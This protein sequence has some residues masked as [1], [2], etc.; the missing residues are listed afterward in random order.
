[1][2]ADRK[3][4]A[5]L[6]AVVSEEYG[7][8]SKGAAESALMNENRRKV[9]EY[10][11]WHPGCS[12]GEIARALSVSGPTASW[13]LGKLVAAGYATGP[14]RGR[15]RRFSAAGMN[16]TESEMSALSA[17]ADSTA[18]RIF[19]DTLAT[20]GLTGAQLAS[21]GRRG[22]AHRA[23]RQL[24]DADLLVTVEDG[25]FRRYYPGPAADVLEKGAVKRLREFRKRLVRRLQVDRLAPE[26][27][28]APG[29]VVEID[30]HFGGEHTTIRLPASSL[31]AG[32]L[33]RIN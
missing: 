16:F 8:E 15:N 33:G 30:L 26:V 28:A 31:L 19:L 23:I 1:M 24:V 5:A 7:S 21:K 12:P 10:V 4:G 6:K 27:R 32:R 20:P 25:R 22:G 3:L 14:L 29:D 9:F 11:A 13:H 17:L 18:N 2:S